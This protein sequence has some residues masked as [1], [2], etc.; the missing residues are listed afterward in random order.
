MALAIVVV[1][2]L[3]WSAYQKYVDPPGNRLLKIHLAGVIPVIREPPGKRFAI[4]IART[5][6]VSLLFTSG[7][8]LEF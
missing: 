2:Y 7:S 5:A 4:P 1:F 8:N 3:P 6:G